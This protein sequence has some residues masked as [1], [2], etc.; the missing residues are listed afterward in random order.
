[1]TTI[2]L[3]RPIRIENGDGPPRYPVKEALARVRDRIYRGDRCECACC[4]RSFKLFLY[5]NYM[6]A[7]CPYCLSVERYRLL[8]KYLRE[9]TDFGSYPMRVLDIAPMWCFQEF[10]R[11]FENVE[12]T[13]IDIESRLAMRHMDIRDLEFKDDHFDRI[14]CYHVLE[15]IDDDRKAMDELYRVLKPGGQAVIQVPIFTEATIERDEL[16]EAEAEDLL[17]YDCH[18]RSYGRDFGGILAVSGFD[19]VVV[20]FARRFSVEE[21]KRF[22]LDCTEDLYVCTK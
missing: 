5:S 12:Y 1:M 14:I 7:L 20:D 19:V 13:S 4:G 2:R 8:C 17:K 16:S 3:E 9:K 18:L 15:H 21:L 10:C 6:A 22:G 11:S